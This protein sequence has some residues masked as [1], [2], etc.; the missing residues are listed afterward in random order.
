MALGTD[1]AAQDCALAAALELLGERWTL[2]IVRD[3]FYGVRRYSDFLVHLDI[4]RAVLATRLQALVES[5]VLDRRP[6]QEGPR[7]EEYVL[8]KKGRALWPAINALAHWG[9]EHVTSTGPYRVYV[10]LG[11]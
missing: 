7:R 5:G 8:T 2:L 11:C 4:P 6:Y 1:Y 3:A 9:A 10:H